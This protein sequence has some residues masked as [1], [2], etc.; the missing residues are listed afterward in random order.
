MYVFKQVKKIKLVTGKVE[1]TVI[2][3]YRSSYISYY[4]SS[5][6]HLSMLNKDDPATYN[7]LSLLSTHIH[8]KAFCA[9]PKL[10]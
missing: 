9:F 10:S 6:P 7:I 5:F 3:I 2:L 8:N 1:I 4:T